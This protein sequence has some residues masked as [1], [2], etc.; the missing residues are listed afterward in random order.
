M[1]TTQCI[2]RMPTD[3]SACEAAWLYLAAKMI[4]IANTT[5]TRPCPYTVLE[6]MKRLTLPPNLV[7]VPPNPAAYF[8]GMG[9]R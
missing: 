7:M 6:I 9:R 2:P 1:H 8:G 3:E 5:K 4:A